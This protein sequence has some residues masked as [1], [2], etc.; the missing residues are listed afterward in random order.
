MDTQERKKLTTAARFGRK[1]AARSKDGMIVTSHPV[2]TRIGADVLRNGGN[3]CDAALAAS[4]AQTVIEPHM[5]TLCGVLSQLYF[6]ATTGTTTYVNGA[7][8]APRAPLSGFGPADIAGGRGVAVPGFWAGFEA[9]LARHGSKCPAELLAP[10]IELAREGFEIHPFLYGMM[11]EAVGKLAR[12]AEGRELFFPTGALLDP[13]ETLRQPRLADTLERLAAEGS[14][15]FYRG[16]WARNFVGVVQAAGGVLTEA[17]M[18]SYEVRWQEPAWGTYRDYRVAAS[19]PPDNGGT[20]L[21][22]I[23]NLVE[24]IDLAA[25]GPPT[26]SADTLYWLLRFCSEVFIEGTKQGDPRTHHVPLET[27]LSKEW[28]RIRFDLMKMSAPRAADV[29]PA[30]PGSCHI[31]AMDRQGNVSTILNSVMSMPWS[32]GLY[33]DGVQ[34]WAAGAHFLRLLPG[35]GE[36]GTCPVAPTIFFDGERPVLAAGSP[37]LSLVHNVLQNSLNILD[38]GMDIEH[39]VHRPRFGGFAPGS[40]LMPGEQR[41][42]IEGDIDQRLIDDVSRRGLTLEV[43]GPWHHHMGSFEGVLIDTA[44]GVASA[45]ADPRRA[46]AAEGI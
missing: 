42:M 8:N 15:Y 12:S 5:T 38:F 39:S 18:E 30:Y 23:L 13:G 17:D 25:W 46:G 45:C 34:V 20:H 31:T 22:E 16:E 7:M 33:V 21:I 27:I 41:H 11:F 29:P 10:S 1:A 37:S 26:E 9:A 28:A 32:N 43:V 40:T 4:V 19:P 2:A 3:A 44:T 24:L 35:P 6:D 36:R 14:D